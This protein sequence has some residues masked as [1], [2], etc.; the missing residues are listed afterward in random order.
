LTLNALP[1]RFG[2]GQDPATPIRAHRRDM[3]LT[4]HPTTGVTRTTVGPLT[5]RRHAAHVLVVL[6]V[7]FVVCLT[8]L[9][10]TK[11]AGQP[12]SGPPASVEILSEM[13][14]QP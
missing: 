8:S 3:A 13:N 4:L 2:G 12:A 1:S 7:L 14:A 10:T 6:A 9:A 5:Y 11:S